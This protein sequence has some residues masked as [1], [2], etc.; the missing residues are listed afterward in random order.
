VKN[1]SVRYKDINQLGSFQLRSSS[2]VNGWDIEFLPSFFLTPTFVYRPVT[3]VVEVV[4]PQITEINCE[5]KGPRLKQLLDGSIVVEFPPFSGHP[6]V[7]EL[8]KKEKYSRPITPIRELKGKYEIAQWMDKVSYENADGGYEYEVVEKKNFTPDWMERTAAE[9]IVNNISEATPVVAEIR[10]GWG[11]LHDIPSV[12]LGD[13]FGYAP[14]WFA[15]SSFEIIIHPEL[16]EVRLNYGFLDAL[17]F[18]SPR[19]NDSAACHLAFHQYYYHTVERRTRIYKDDDKD[20][21]PDAN[22]QYRFFYAYDSGIKTNYGGRTGPAFHY[23]YGLG[24]GAPEYRWGFNYQGDAME[25]NTYRR[26]ALLA[27]QDVVWHWPDNQSPP[28][29]GSYEWDLN[30]YFPD[31]SIKKIKSLRVFVSW[32]SSIDSRDDFEYEIMNSSIKSGLDYVKFSK[33]PKDQFT[34]NPKL[35]VE[36]TEPA[37]VP[38]VISPWELIALLARNRTIHPFIYLEITVESPYTPK[39]Y[40]ASMAEPGSQYTGNWSTWFTE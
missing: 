26:T 39:D 21:L 19:A 28:F 10:K 7:Y 9:A 5:Y 37:H 8:D 31:Y 36:L 1:P 16:K 22:E 25:D 17:G 20:K 18:Y 4:D 34:K 23:T 24:P 13:Y 33:T 27:I 14:T 12:T 38:G 40:D 15:F 29:L 2:W 35:V 3:V 32:A 30:D 6:V 11:M